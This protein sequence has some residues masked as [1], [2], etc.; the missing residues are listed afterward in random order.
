M[1]SQ[2]N[3]RY[4]TADYENVDPYAGTNEILKSLCDRAHQK[5][6]K[7]ILDAVF[8][9]TGNDSICVQ[10]VINCFIRGP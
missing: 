7:V 6:M 10:K 9:H 5:G 4:D 2:S 1:R 3:H 8:N